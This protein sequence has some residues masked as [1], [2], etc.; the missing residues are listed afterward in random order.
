MAECIV[1]SVMGR[2]RFAVLTL[3]VL[4][5]CGFARAASATLEGYYWPL[6]VAPGDTLTFAV[7]S[8]A[9]YQVTF[10]RYHR[11]NDTNVGTPLATMTNLPAGVQAPPDSAWK[12]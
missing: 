8:T 11:Q 10:M 6:S 3:V 2:T 9:N 12:G 5:L 7:S 4:G 1:N